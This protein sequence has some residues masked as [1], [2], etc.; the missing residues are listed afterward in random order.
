M[1]VSR[2]RVAGVVILLICCLGII[3]VVTRTLGGAPQLHV[4]TNVLVDANG[5]KVVLRGVDISGTEYRCVRKEGIFAA[6]TSQVSIAAMKSWGINAVRI[7]LNEACWN[8]ASYV[9]PT[10]AGAKYQASIKAY[11]NLLNANGIIVILDLHWTSGRYTGLSS[12]CISA[13]AICQKPMPDLAGSV[14]FWAS[15]ATSFR[16]DDSVIFDLFNEPYPDHAMPTLS[17][18]WECW[19]KGGSLCSP[20]IAFPVAGMQA[21]VDVVRSA[22]ANNVIMIGGLDYSNDLDEW[23]RYEPIDPDH[24]LVASWHSYSSER[25][26]IQ[27]CWTDEISPVIKLVPVIAGEIGEFD[28]TNNYIDRLMVYLDSKSTSYLVWT[29]NISSNCATGLGLIRNYS[30]KPTTYGAGYKYHLRSLEDKNHLSLSRWR[31]DPRDESKLG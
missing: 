19:L 14:P 30:G 17:S 28:C 31:K 26:A 29:W 3:Q 12:E 1:R 10:Y 11:V 6:P 21:L 9:D 8:G 7:P 23:S 25:C 24:N 2:F 27:L 18:A 22:G 5:S 15:V 4:S 20:Y 16:N 13:E